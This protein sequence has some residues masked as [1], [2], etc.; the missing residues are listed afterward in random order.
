MD[1]TSRI[2]RCEYSGAIAARVVR[3]STGGEVLMSAEH[4]IYLRLDGGLVL[5]CGTHM[6]RIG[7]ALELE[8]FEALFPKDKGMEGARVSCGENSLSFCGKNLLLAEV[9]PRSNGAS[10][11]LAVLS[12]RGEGIKALV[13][14]AGK[15]F[16]PLL[17][18]FMGEITG[19]VPPEEA[20]MPDNKY[21][22]KAAKSMA[23]LFSALRRG[24]DD[25]ICSAFVNVPGL[26]PGLTPST[27]DW[28]AGLLYTL[29]ALAPE[30]ISERVRSL[31]PEGAR[32]RTNLIS[33]AYLENACTGGELEMMERLLH[34]GEAE[35]AR[36]L[37]SVG[38]SSGSDMLCGYLSGLAYLNNA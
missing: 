3:E 17:L 15:G 4:G 19:G 34:T 22:L 35:D 9:K 18:P 29:S 38:S 8:D 1:M 26:G 7:F 20:S 33:L 27:D 11:P 5:L 21:A 25:E 36:R 32:E 37:L 12:E 13:T 6:G 2:I 10:A 14:A 23:A 31:I 24:R 16:L 30:S 28:T